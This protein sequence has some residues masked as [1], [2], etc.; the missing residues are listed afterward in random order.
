MHRPELEA[1]MIYNVNYEVRD[2]AGIHRID[3][4][5]DYKYECSGQRGVIELR[6]TGC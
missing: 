5:T 2:F 1:R 6:S 3:S 4:T